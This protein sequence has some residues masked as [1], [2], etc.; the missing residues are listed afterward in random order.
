MNGEARGWRNNNPLN[1]DYHKEIGWLGLANPPSDGRFARFTSLAYG[2]RAGIVNAR[3]YKKQHGIKTLGE[4]MAR[5]APVGPENSSKYHDFV[6]QKANHRLNDAIDLENREDLEP[7][8]RAQISYEN[9]TPLNEVDI[10]VPREVWDAAFS[11]AK[12]MTKS[13]TVGGAAGAA[14][15]TVAGAVVE[16]VSQNTDQ[17]VAAGG[18]AASIWPKWAPIIAAVVAL[19]FIGVVL[20]AR[21]SARS[22]GVR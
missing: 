3:A 21:L 12:P 1:L 17:I 14:A 7:I 20:Y 18:A 10:R 9:G 8:L 13:R 2:L 6:A 4:Y 11:L 5:F 15:A 16:V 19:C 22:E